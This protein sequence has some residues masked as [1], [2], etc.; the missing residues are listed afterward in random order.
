MRVSSPRRGRRSNSR[1]RQPRSCR[2]STPHPAI[3]RRCST[4]CL[5]RRYTCAERLSAPFTYTTMS[6]STLPLTTV[7]HQSM[8]NFFRQHRM[9]L[10]SVV[11]LLSFFVVHL[12]SI[13][14]LL[15]VR[16]I[17]KVIHCPACL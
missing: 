3:L 4:L 5:K 13:W 12:S 16:C 15:K 14:T 9:N 17:A 11:P 6:I 2:S 1:P 10:L 8:H 7:Y